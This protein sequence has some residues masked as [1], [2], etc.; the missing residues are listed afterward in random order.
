MARRRRV[1]LDAFHR[2]L[3]RRLPAKEAACR[4]RLWRR[5][6]R[7]L[8]QAERLELDSYMG[9]RGVAWRARLAG[10]RREAR[11]VLSELMGAYKASRG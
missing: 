9:G 10:T 8:S 2:W 7:L 5:Y 3:K 4:D 1:D 6:Q 11:K